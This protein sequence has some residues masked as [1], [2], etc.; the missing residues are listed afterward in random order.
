M[1]G[2]LAPQSELESVVRDIERGSISTAAELCD[3]LQQI[4]QHYK[5][6]E[7]AYA[8]SIMQQQGS[9]LFI[10][11]DHWFREA[12]EAHAL[13]L[14]MVKDDAEK[15]FQMGD[16]DAEQLRDFLESVK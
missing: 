6:Y 13:W 7:Q 14:K 12:E 10:D 3:I 4:H 5:E 2:L 8:N 15:E 16:V 1:M 9:N 11:H